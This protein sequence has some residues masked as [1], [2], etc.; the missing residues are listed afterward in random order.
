MIALGPT[1]SLNAGATSAATVNCVVEGQTITAGSPPASAS[2]G[3]LF[4]GQLGGSV[5]QI[6]SPGTSTE[7]LVSRIALF[8]TSG[9]AVTVTW[10][11][12]GT[13]SA[14]H[15]ATIQLVANGWAEYEPGSG[16]TM[17][18]ANGTVTQGITEIVSNDRSVG[19]TDPGGPTTVLSAFQPSWLY[20][21][22]SDGPLLFTAT[23]RT[24]TDAVLTAGSVII[25]SEMADF[26]SADINL[27]LDDD[28]VRVGGLGFM[29]LG[30]RIIAVNSPTEAVLSSSVGQGADG[31]PDDTVVIGSGLFTAGNYSSITLPTGATARPNTVGTVPYGVVACSGEFSI[32]GT[33][34]LS[35]VG[36]TGSGGQC[37]WP[38]LGGNGGDGDGHDA[39]VSFATANP[40]FVQRGPIGLIDLNTISTGT[41]SS[42]GQGSSDGGDNVGGF[43]GFGGIPF[44][45]CAKSIVHGPNATYNLQGANGADATAGN[46]GGGGGGPDGWWMT[47]SD[48]IVG[49]PTVIGGG[50]NGGHGHGTGTDGT[51]GQ[52]GFGVHYLPGTVV[53]QTP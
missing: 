47:A 46:T 45:I 48:T 43:G 37:D 50:G 11:E 29:A 33:V 18:S 51:A 5:A 31:E 24:V 20:G 36:T 23:P 40:N 13:T 52:P 6:Y 42:G 28:T 2:F 7:A 27:V 17:Y 34:D 19:I 49:S 21:D 15:T 39:A 3:V 32:D 41:Q 44:R 8:N 25:T 26:T 30:T 22:G 38:P 4:A 10:A 35:G 53:V 14:H 12:N 9:S 16:W 1:D